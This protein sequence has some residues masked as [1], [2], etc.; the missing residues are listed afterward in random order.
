[1]NSDGMYK[2]LQNESNVLGELLTRE[3]EDRP[4][5][6]ALYLRAYSRPPSDKQWSGIQEFLASE[7][8]AGRTRRRAFENLMMVL[9]NSK[10]FQVNR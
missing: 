7:R 3:P 4:A 2:M 9:I 10:E 8:A 5:V 1:M 6:S